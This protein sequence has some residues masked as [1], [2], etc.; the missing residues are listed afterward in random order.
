[1]QLLFLVLALVLPLDTP[2]ATTPQATAPQVADTA[3]AGGGATPYDSVWADPEVPTQTSTG[4]EA[5]ML[6]DDKLFVVLAVVLVIWLGIA[7]YLLR[8]DRKIRELEEATGA[9]KED[10]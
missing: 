5:V 7:A 9:T 6:S 4:F 1:M 2:Q 3:Q 8:T 10:A